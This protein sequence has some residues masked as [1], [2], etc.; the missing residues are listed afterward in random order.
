MTGVIAVLL[1]IKFQGNPVPQIYFGT[2]SIPVGAAPG[3]SG[4]TELLREPNSLRSSAFYGSFMRFSLDF[5]LKRRPLMGA[6]C[7]NL[8]LDPN[9]CPKNGSRPQRF[10]CFRWPAILWETRAKDASSVGNNLSIVNRGQNIL[11][12]ECPCGYTIKQ[13]EL[14]ALDF[15]Q[16]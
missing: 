12:T 1:Q 7:F 13:P 2:P 10:A 8:T 9:F 11:D 4:D 14:V 5:V 15:I 16:V 6:F 3:N